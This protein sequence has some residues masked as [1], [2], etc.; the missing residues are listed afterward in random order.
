MILESPYPI[1]GVTEHEDLRGKEKYK[2]AKTRAR[3]HRTYVETNEQKQPLI[4]V[5]K[6]EKKYS[7]HK[8]K[9][10]MSYAVFMHPN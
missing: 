9:C 2:H 4:F 8:Q 1:E 6:K 10:R 7:Y 3:A 5:I